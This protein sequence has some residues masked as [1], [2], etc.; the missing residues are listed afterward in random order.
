[1]KYDVLSKFGNNYC[2]NYV[3][4]LG[5]NTRAMNKTG[6]YKIA[7]NYKNYNSEFEPNIIAKF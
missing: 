4:Y 2:R 3:S 1:V 6:V 7:N 5:G